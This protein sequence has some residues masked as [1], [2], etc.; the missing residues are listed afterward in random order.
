MSKCRRLARIHESGLGDD[1]SGSDG[2][3]EVHLQSAILDQS[4]LSA[5][6]SD[7][8]EQLRVFFVDVQI[9]TGKA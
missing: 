6:S 4:N 8:E 9:G 2:H 3:R 1:F 7:L 5:S